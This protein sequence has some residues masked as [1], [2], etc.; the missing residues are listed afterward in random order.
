MQRTCVRAI[1][2]LSHAGSWP[3]LA[4][5]CVFYGCAADKTT[6]A[7]AEDELLCKYS[8][9]QVDSWFLLGRDSLH[10]TGMAYWGKG[11]SNNCLE[12][13]ITTDAIK[14]DVLQR[15]EAL[16]IP[17]DAVYIKLVE[18]PTPVA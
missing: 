1:R 7:D 18:P 10:I 2:W 16:H 6:G 5:V 11:G 4:F 14:P 12:V 3:V 13:G 9:S 8:A 15:L 17:A